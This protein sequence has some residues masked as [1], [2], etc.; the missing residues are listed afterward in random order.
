MPSPRSQ[1]PKA[2]LGSSGSSSVRSQVAFASGVKRLRR[3]SCSAPCGLAFRR[4]K[5]PIPSRLVHDRREVKGIGAAIDR[6]ALVATVGEQLLALGAG[7][8]F[9]DAWLFV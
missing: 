7:E 9:H 1:K 8:T 4:F 5:P 6:G 2:R 3:T